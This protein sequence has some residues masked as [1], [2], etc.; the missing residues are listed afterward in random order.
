[1]PAGQANVCPARYSP[2]GSM[3]DRHYNTLS[4]LAATNPVHFSL[5]GKN[6]FDDPRR[7][8][9]GQPRIQALELDGEALVVD[10]AEREEGGM[11]VMD[12]HHILDRLI[13]ELIGS[14]IG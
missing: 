9:P 7:L 1:M 4:P 13:A 10:A 2:L 5:S 6:F 11:E 3:R 8:D 14:P 12:A